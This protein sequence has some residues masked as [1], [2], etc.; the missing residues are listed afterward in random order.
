MTCF[1]YQYD[2]YYSAR[3]LLSLFV[4]FSLGCSS[5]PMTG[6]CTVTTDLT[7]RVK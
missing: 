2:T 5:T 4:F 7:M 6:A 3:V 1:I